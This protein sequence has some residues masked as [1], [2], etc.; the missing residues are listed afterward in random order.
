MLSFIGYLVTCWIAADFISGIFHWL[1]DRY[2]RNHWPIIGKY[3]ATPNELHHKQPSAFLVG[4]YWRRN[5]TTLAVA[6]PSFVMLFPNKWC[7]IF[8]MASQANEIHA[9]AH[10]RCGRWVRVLQTTG[11][12]QSPREHGLHHQSP[13]AVRYCPLSNWLNP[14]LDEIKF[15]QM[16]EWVIL[17]ATGLQVK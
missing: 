14:I 15:W 3:I 4:G 6:L 11:I 8:L 7:L 9:W 10:Q 16:L 2:A 13:Y 12:L 5:W 17:K 1:E